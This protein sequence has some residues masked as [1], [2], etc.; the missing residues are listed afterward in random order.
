MAND[1]SYVQF[2]LCALA[3]SLDRKELA[4]HLMC[5]SI[6]VNG[7]RI[8]RDCDDEKKEQL[9]LHHDLP[10][11][12][13]DSCELIV[14]TGAEHCG[15]SSDNDARIMQKHLLVQKHVDGWEKRHGSDPLVRIRSSLC[16]QLREGTGIS[17]REFRVL[18]AIYSSIG[19][20][21]YPVAIPQRMIAAR[22][23]GCK[24]EKVREVESQ[25]RDAANE[26]V[27]STP[28]QLRHTIQRLH[29]LRWYSRVTPHPR[30]RVTYYQHLA[31]FTEDDIRAHLLKKHTYRASFSQKERDKNAAYQ[32]QLRQIKAGLHSRD[33]SI[34]VPVPITVMDNLGQQKG[35]YNRNALK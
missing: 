29:E 35:D 1:D 33:E 31:R 2:P 18:A 17:L 7:Q 5:H 13:E 32:E 22:V 28:K 10:V 12:Y 16:V 30:G 19:S 4:N 11:E 34:P 3:M 15:F 6:I 26:L 8:L 21:K 14:R 27:Q 20:K 23:A 25:R 24:S 9:Y